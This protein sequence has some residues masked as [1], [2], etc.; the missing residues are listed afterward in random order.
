M[1]AISTPVLWKTSSNSSDGGSVWTKLGAVP[2]HYSSLVTLR[3]RVLAIG[4]AHDPAGD[5]PTGAIHCY[6]VTSNLWSVVGEIPTP[7]YWV[8]ATVLSSNDLVVVGGRLSMS[9]NCSI[10]DVGSCL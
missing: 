2:V 5:N 6:N 9:E 3:G 8:L 4:G 7:R 10:T 1:G